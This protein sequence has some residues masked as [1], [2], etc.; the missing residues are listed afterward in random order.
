MK[1]WTKQIAKA[2]KKLAQA[3]KSNG[4]RGKEWLGIQKAARFSIPKSYV[5]YNKDGAPL[6]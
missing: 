1:K 2:I 4:R 6:N 5:N 3:S